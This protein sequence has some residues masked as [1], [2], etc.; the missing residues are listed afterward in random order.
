ME[1]LVVFWFR[2]DLRL[3]DNHGLYH[4]LK[5]EYKVLP[6]FIF[7]PEI[8][9]RYTDIENR[10]IDFLINAVDG[11]KEDLIQS[12]SDLLIY[13]DTPLNVFEKLNDEFNIKMVFANEEYEPHCI[14]RDGKISVYLNSKNIGFNLFTDHLIRKPGTIL[15]SDGTP[16]TIFTPFAKQWKKALKQED[17]IPFPVKEMVGNLFQTTQIFE[18]DFFQL[19]YRFNLKPHV[20]KRI[21]LQVIETYDQTR[22]F[23]AIKNGTTQLGVHLR[24]GTISIRKLV[25][26][27]MTHNEQFLNELIWREFFMHILFHFPQ[28]V[29]GAFRSKYNAI[30]WRNDEQEFNN[31]C[32]GTTGVPIV[33]AGMRQ[34]N[35]TDLMHN[36]V[37][38]IVASYLVKHLLIDWRWGEAYFAQKLLDFELSANNGNWQW[39]AGT[40]CD[41]APYFRIF[42][43]FRQQERFDPNFEYIRQWVP[44]YQSE[45]YLKLFTLDLKEAKERCLRA[46]K[47]CNL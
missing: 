35:Q 47:A 24:F 36:R 8:L 22:D 10:Q 30:S 37:R 25:A 1:E 44:E 17:I 16:Y 45:S 13:Y 38:M 33:D 39:A 11:L 27:A 46:Y 4:A 29:D 5:S 7:D 20:K 28:V 32:N 31:W 42:N 14:S 2:R 41:A 23:P 15:K 34:L 3:D 21:P 19:G 12:S 26:D 9:S 40:G 6:I 18:F 43:P